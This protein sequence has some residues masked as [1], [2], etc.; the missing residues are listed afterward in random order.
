MTTFKAIS[1]GSATSSS[2]VFW[3]QSDQ[4]VNARLVYGETQHGLKRG[5]R[6][7]INISSDPNADN[8]LK[9]SLTGLK[10][11]TVYSY[12]F[13]TPEGTNS[14][15][16]TVKTAPDSGAVTG[17]RF[18]F[19]GC[20]SARYAPY[21]SLADIPGQRLDFFVMLGDAA[22]EDS[23]NYRTG[24]PR[25]RSPEAPV[26]FD[27]ANPGVSSN[28][29]IAR[30]VTGMAGK[31]QD[32]L[33][34]TVGNLAPLYRSQGVLSAYDNHEMVDMAL[35]TGG[36]PRSV[37]SAYLDDGG[38]QAFREGG[39]FDRTNTNNLI[40]NRSGNFLNK[41]LEHRAMVD[42]WLRYMPIA[43]PE[44]H[45][46]PA[47]PRTD[48]TY[49]LYNAQQWG[50]NALFINVDDRSYRDAK[51]TQLKPSGSG[52]D[53]S[54]YAGTDADNQPITESTID[55]ATDA[56]QR[57]VLGATQLAWLKQTLLDS[58]K[59]GTTWKFISLSSPIDIT[60]RQADGKDLLA[61]NAGGTWIDAKSWWGNYRYERNEL[62]RFIA[63]NGIKNVV[64][65][66]TDDHEARINEVSYAPDN[67]A[68]D[69]LTNYRPL[70]GAI[71]VVSSPIGAIRPDS[72]S[73][74]DLLTLSEEL[75]K[76]YLSRNLDPIGLRAGFPGLVSLKRQPVGTHTQADVN[77]PKA[78][79]FWSP[80]TFNYGLMDVNTSGQLTVS[81]RGIEAYARGAW[82]A[83]AGPESVSE[84]LS[85]TLNPLV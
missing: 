56:A 13:S 25:S 67:V 81:I 39:N 85:F 23:Y 22:Y 45:V 80:N 7:L 32:N 30:A 27:P 46:T 9:T 2:A 37:V 3:A 75:T 26:P 73:K 57:T 54:D 62:L 4:S 53:E 59:A 33:D 6:S 11:G 50:K 82:P 35:E 21:N 49:K 61:V 84:I 44:L 8:T 47:D 29:R 69:D 77:N 74:A 31:Y 63:N 20:A 5:Y 19:S 14:A 51:L 58:Q 65:L 28:S 72:F 18:G 60:G 79:D 83:I 76:N 38:S 66:A 48:A 52:F 71:S 15:Q 34:P 12:Q 42:T 68:I 55:T 24:D 40:F 16:G 70:E 17:V 64:F 78:I 36:A 43:S 10:P 1:A 41:S